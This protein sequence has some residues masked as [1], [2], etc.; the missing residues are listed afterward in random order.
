MNA[1]PKE[2]DCSLLYILS[3]RVSF[4]TL[5]LFEGA[6]GIDMPTSERDF[7]GERDAGE[8]C[9]V[10]LR[11]RQTSITNWLSAKSPQAVREATASQVRK[12]VTLRD[13]STPWEV[14]R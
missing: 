11:C 1:F 14:E 8:A 5:G 3:L 10:L 7:L 6:S 13:A 2:T 12:P 4:Q 9:S